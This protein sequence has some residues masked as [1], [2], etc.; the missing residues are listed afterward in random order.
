MNR[1]HIS[2]PDPEVIT[3]LDW[4]AP[5]DWVEDIRQE[6]Q[7]NLYPTGAGRPHHNVGIIG[8]PGKYEFRSE[9]QLGPFETLRG[10]RG[11]PS[12]NYG[13][14]GSGI[15]VSDNWQGSEDQFL[16][17]TELPGWGK[18]YQSFLNGMENLH[19]CCT[20]PDGSKQVN[21]IE[22]NASQQ[23]EYRDLV[24]KGVGP[25][26]VG[27]RIS[28]DVF[29]LR[30]CIFDRDMTGQRTPPPE[31]ESVAIEKGPSRLVGV[32]VER[33]TIHNF[34]TGIEMGDMAGC[35]FQAEMET[36]RIPVDLTFSAV[37]CE[38]DLTIQHADCIARISRA[39]FNNYRVR[40]KGIAAKTL[41]RIILPDGS[42]WWLNS[43]RRKVPSWTPFDLLITKQAGS[44]HVQNYTV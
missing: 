43:S 44:V 31:D 2:L 35:R 11:K 15:R 6:V 21:G 41:T 1:H 16:V 34:A 29:T 27:A 37:G 13:S 32:S 36:T 14:S 25:G 20:S 24:I 9:L 10:E 23:S 7:P 30:N 3:R 4:D 26:G 22:I 19:L 39:A 5:V 17:R 42:D 12:W 8:L 33:C 40:I 28:G 18:Y 38:V